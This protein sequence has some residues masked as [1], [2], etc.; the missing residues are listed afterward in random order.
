MGVGR[1]ERRDSVELDKY[2]TGRR[3]EGVRNKQG[4]EERD[5]KVVQGKYVPM[6]KYLCMSLRKWLVLLL[7]KTDKRK[8]D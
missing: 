2:G 4:V 1:C 3:V 5:W 6:I 8:H 7:S